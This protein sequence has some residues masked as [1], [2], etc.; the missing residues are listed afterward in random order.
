ML[1]LIVVGSDLVRVVVSE[2]ILRNVIG[3]LSVLLMRKS[4]SILMICC[5]RRC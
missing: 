3:V 1:S 5:V 2:C 4:V